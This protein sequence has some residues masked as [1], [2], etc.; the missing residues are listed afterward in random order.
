MPTVETSSSGTVA[1]RVAS[2][3]PTCA[4]RKYGF[5]SRY[6][7]QPV[8]HLHVERAAPVDRGGAGLDVPD[9]GELGNHLRVFLVPHHVASNDVLVE[10]ARVGE[11][12]RVAVDGAAELETVR[13]V[14]LRV[15]VGE[16]GTV[17]VDVAASPP[18]DHGR[19]RWRHRLVVQIPSPA[20]TR[21][22]Q[23]PTKCTGRSARQLRHSGRVTRLQPGPCWYAVSN[24]CRSVIPANE[25]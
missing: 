12:H 20:G 19:A 25:S 13:G 11:R 1:N 2:A 3:M 23:P 4:K 24:S 10:L 18:A 21:P 5:H 15:E 6:E 9:T 16:P 8:G 7:R 17:A 22:R 14:G